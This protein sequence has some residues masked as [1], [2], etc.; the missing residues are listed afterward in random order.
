MKIA[1]LFLT[2]ICLSSFGTEIDKKLRKQKNKIAPP[3]TTWIKDSLYM[4]YGEVRNEDYREYLYWLSKIYG[5]ESEKYQ[6]AL[7]DTT[8][9]RDKLSHNEPYVNYYFRHP[10]YGKYPLVGVSFEQAENYCEWRSDRVNEFYLINEKKIGKEI[11]DNV[12]EFVNNPLNRPFLDSLISN[13]KRVKYRMPTK[14]EWEFAANSGQQGRRY[15]WDGPFLRNYK[16][17]IL[18]NFQRVGDENVCYNDSLQRLQV[19]GSSSMIH[20]P[21]MDITAPSKSYWP[22]DFGIYNMSGNVAEM[23]SPQGITKGGSFDLPGYHLRIKVD[24]N[25]SGPQRDIGFRC[26]CEIL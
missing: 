4:D 10:A 14:E 6:S 5:N 17:E 26:A 3:G 25:Y 11:T 16:G 12:T 21:D 8:V 19:V 23:V 24:G 13:N 15:P 9:W 18:A 22:N 1:A 20:I 7:P 2:I